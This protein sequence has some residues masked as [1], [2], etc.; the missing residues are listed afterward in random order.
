MA[1]VVEDGTG[2]ANADSYV[3]AADATAYHELFSN[4]AWASAA[5]DAK[6]VA[7]RKATQ[8]LDSHYKFKGVP[9]TVSQALSWPRVNYGTEEV[10]EYGQWPITR[11]HRACCELALIA[12]AE[13]LFVNQDAQS[14][15]SVT[16]GP[17]TRVMS[18][19][20][21]GGQKRYAKIDAII[22]PVV[23][24]GAGSGRRAVRVERA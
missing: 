23:V 4:A 6:D 5:S 1:L 10:Q 17:I 14:V 8:Y 13:D 3:S 12:L 11:L 16:I 18:D 24:G 2:L 15:K 22:G 21:N 7:L 20:V 9:R 19:P